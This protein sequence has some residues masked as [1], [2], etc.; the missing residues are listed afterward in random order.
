MT[1][2]LSWGS[3][4]GWKA[5]TV[6]DVLYDLPKSPKY[7]VRGCFGTPKGLLWRCL[8]VQTPI[9]KVFGRLGIYFFECLYI[10]ICLYVP[11]LITLLY[12]F[13]YRDYHKLIILQV[14]FLNFTSNDDS[15]TYLFGGTWIWREQLYK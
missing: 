6:V 8:G 4:V 11:D 15:M 10:N 9:L 7:L 5:P 2:T 12:G 1:R 3:R 14:P 13:L